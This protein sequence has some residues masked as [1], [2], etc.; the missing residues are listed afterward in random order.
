MI[1][2]FQ[3]IVDRLKEQVRRRSTLDSLVNPRSA[4]IKSKFFRTE[5]HIH[6]HAPHEPVTEYTKLF[7]ERMLGRQNGSVRIYAKC[8]CIYIFSDIEIPINNTVT[9]LES[10]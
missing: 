9:H 2:A 7:S 10:D 4:K 6:A 1:F 3:T 8:I 5:T